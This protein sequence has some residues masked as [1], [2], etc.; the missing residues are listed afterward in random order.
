MTLKLRMSGRKEGRTESVGGGSLAA[1]RCLGEEG[2]VRG[3][4]SKRQAVGGGRERLPANLSEAR[5]GTDYT[6]RLDGDGW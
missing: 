4:G 6:G 5:E 1:A 3:A 2:G